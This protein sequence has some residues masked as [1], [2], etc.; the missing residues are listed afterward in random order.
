MVLE[1]GY[2]I[3]PKTTEAVTRLKEKTPQTVGEVRRIVG[4]LGVYRRH[5]K[6]FSKIAKPI[7][8]L[9]DGK[10]ISKPGNK[11]S[12]QLPSNHPIQCSAI[13]QQPMNKLI[14]ASRRHQFSRTQI[15]I[16]RSPSTQTL[17]KVE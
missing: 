2:S 15:T 3:D 9:F 17:L 1:Q 16:H 13:H 11:N 7:Y 14:D 5:I 8:E 10:L 4:L 12:G 6:D